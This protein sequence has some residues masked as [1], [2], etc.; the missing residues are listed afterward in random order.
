MN[1][2]EFLEKEKCKYGEDKSPFVSVR[3]L[4]EWA[5]DEFTERKRLIRWH[6]DNAGERDLLQYFKEQTEYI[7]HSSAHFFAYYPIAIAC[8]GE[9]EV[10]KRLE[11]SK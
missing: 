4:G 6:L 7:Y 11:E 10:K 3:A 9:A 1:F 8:L 2:A 5:W